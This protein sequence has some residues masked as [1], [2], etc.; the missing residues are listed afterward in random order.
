M[1][2]DSDKNLMF[3]CVLSGGEQKMKFA[4]RSSLAC[5]L[6]VQDL[7]TFFVSNIPCFQVWFGC[8]R[9]KIRGLNQKQREGYFPCQHFQFPAFGT[10]DAV[11]FGEPVTRPWRGKLFCLRPLRRTVFFFFLWRRFWKETRVVVLGCSN[12]CTGKGL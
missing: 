6:W 11:Q 1:V 9:L 2:A 5:S 4:R 7:T 3:T 10:Q 8:V 12:C